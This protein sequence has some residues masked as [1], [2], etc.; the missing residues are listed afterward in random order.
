MRTDNDYVSTGEL[1]RMVGV[2]R[3]TIGNWIRSG[4]LKPDRKTLGG[5]GK[6]HAQ[7]RRS[8]ARRLAERMRGRQAAA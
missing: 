3:S 4:E 5:K 1:A 2:S 8:T 7:F 6:G